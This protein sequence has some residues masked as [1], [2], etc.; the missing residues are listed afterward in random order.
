MMWD[1]GLV[2]AGLRCDLV[3]D[4]LQYANEY[5]AFLQ[6]G[7]H[8]YLLSVN[9]LITTPWIV[10]LCVTHS[11]NWAEGGGCYYRILLEILIVV[12]L[13]KK[14]NSSYEVR[15]FITT[16]SRASRIHSTASHT[17]FVRI[18]DYNFVFP[19]PCKENYGLRWLV[20]GHY[21]VFIKA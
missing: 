15:W 11:S 10:K 2:W 18:F 17:G 4:F 5:S 19:C 16:A 14:L 1:Y 13:L 7:R 8:R 9:C 21:W 12:R 3:T 20:S 6:R